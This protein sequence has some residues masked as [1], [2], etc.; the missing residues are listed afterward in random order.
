MCSAEFTR[1]QVY[2]AL[3]KGVLTTGHVLI[4]PI[5]HAA[6]SVELDEVRHTHMRDATHVLQ[7]TQTEIEQYKRSLGEYYASK[8]QSFV[9]FERN[10]RSQHMQLQAREHTPRGIVSCDAG[11]AATPRGGRGS[12]EG[13]C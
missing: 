8:G 12:A 6:S 13:V 2:V 11:G 4:V 5:N 10:V 9:I 1:P 7:A 3:A